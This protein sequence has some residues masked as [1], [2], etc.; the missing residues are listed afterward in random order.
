MLTSIVSIL[1]YMVK[2][3]KREARE[4]EMEGGRKGRKGREG[5]ESKNTRTV[6]EELLPTDHS[7]KNAYIVTHSQQHE[8]NIRMNCMSI[9]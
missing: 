6:R 4:R 7:E 5:E 1:F 2:E 8:G 9:G 3:G